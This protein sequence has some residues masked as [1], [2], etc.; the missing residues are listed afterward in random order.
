MPPPESP[1]QPL[2]EPSFPSTIGVSLTVLG[3][4]SFLM[5]STCSIQRHG[6][7]MNPAGVFV[8]TGGTWFCVNTGIR[9]ASE[10]FR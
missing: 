6:F 10:V 7:E 5:C 1:K 2:R 9:A 3:K 8:P 4:V